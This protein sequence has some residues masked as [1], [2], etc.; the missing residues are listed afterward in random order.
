MED[1]VVRTICPE[2]LT[3]ELYRITQAEMATLSKMIRW[4]NEQLQLINRVIAVRSGQQAVIIEIRSEQSFA[5]PQERIA[6]TDRIFLLN[7]VFRTHPHHQFIDT[8]ASVH[9]LTTVPID[10]RGI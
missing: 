4:T 5:V 8:I 6:L 3:M 9:C 7:K 1:H 2:T 10:I